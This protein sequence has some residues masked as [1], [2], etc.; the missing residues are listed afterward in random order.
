MRKGIVLAATVLIC[1]LLQTSVFDMI[2]MAGISPNILLI[3]V[4]SLA[5]MRG[6]KDGMLVGFFCGLLLDIFFGRII[7]GYAFLYMMFGFCAGFFNRIYYQ[8]D[9]ILPL[10]SLAVGDLIYGLIMYMGEGMLHGHLQILH[11]LRKIILPEMVYT[12]AV[13]FL[14]YRLLL[15]LNAWI[16]KY[17]PGNADFI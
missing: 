1:F 17:E 7:G 13:G 6:Q 12:I 4:V 15:R 14:L 16:D 2:R 5:L 9:N 3:L 8:D 11:Y 10:I